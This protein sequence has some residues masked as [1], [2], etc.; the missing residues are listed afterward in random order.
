MKRKLTAIF[1]CLYRNDAG[2]DLAEYCLL[3]ALLV[4]V[5]GGIFFHVSG[6]MQNL[7]SNANTRLASGAAA[8]TASATASAPASGPAK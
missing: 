7:W 2:Q 1:R 6:G 3:T 8:P 5:A 4:L